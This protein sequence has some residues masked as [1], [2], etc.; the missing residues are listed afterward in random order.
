MSD[1]GD[2]V[3]PLEAFSGYN[4]W[5]DPT[6][7]VLVLIAVVAGG[8]FVA[9]TALG[10]ALG[11]GGGGGVF[12]VIDML[13][14]SD[15][16][17]GALTVEVNRTRVTL[18][19]QVSFRVV[20]DEG[21]P[22]RNATVSVAG[23]D[24]EVDDNGS[25]VV[26]MG[27]EGVHEARA[28][29]RKQD[30]RSVDTEGPSVDVEPRQVPLAIQSNRSRATAGEPLRLT[31]VRDDDR[32]GAVRG[33]IAAVLI[34]E[35]PW[36]DAAGWDRQRA[37]TSG[38]ELVVEPAEA[39][40]LYV[41]GRRDA[42]GGERFE[43]AVRTIPVDRRSVPLRLSLERSAVTV[44]ESLG[45]RL[46]RSDT[47]ERIAGTV[48]AGEQT[49]ETGD[50]GQATLTFATAGDRELRATA[51]STPAVAFE[52]TAAAVTVRPRTVALAIEVNRSTVAAGGSVDVTV[53]R[54]DTG[55]PVNASVAVG[56]WSAWTG[57]DGELAL[58]VETV[59]TYTVTASRPD[60]DRETFQAA[61]ATLT[62]E[63]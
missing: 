40:R 21:R 31:L 37:S 11:G 46:R 5:R 24:Y 56:G 63:S 7:L 60:T 23:R 52:P 59:G 48:T 33:D 15:G 16:D 32:G 45:L 47:D 4:P 44:D 41:T 39:G 10:P 29:T 18:G 61:E 28:S 13:T 35:D 19:E 27:Q 34:P 53:T 26:R 58:P 22:L 57:A 17:G 1:G 54:E 30:G 62:V 25:V 6:V 12:P 14:G 55:A 2:R 51:P 8:M 20:D 49:V 3:G 43:P 36:R 50:D 9:G 42:G 38:A